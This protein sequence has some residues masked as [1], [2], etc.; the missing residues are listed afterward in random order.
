MRHKGYH[1]QEL[2]LQAREGRGSWGN[3]AA[4]RVAPLGAW[5]A[6]DLDRVV[7]EATASAMVTHTHPDA[8]AGAGVPP[9]WFAR[10]EPLPEWVWLAAGNGP[11]T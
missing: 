10:C 1:W 2:A 4:M 5:F 6:D 9:D 7:D 8:V 3:G 11:S